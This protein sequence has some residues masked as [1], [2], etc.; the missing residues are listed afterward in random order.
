MFSDL[1]LLWISQLCDQIFR[2]GASTIR[3]HLHG[4]DDVHAEGLT[5]PRG[6]FMGEIAMWSACAF[7]GLFRPRAKCDVP[8]EPAGLVVERGSDSK[9]LAG[10]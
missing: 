1:C 4:R 2:A 9:L 5:E 10:R 3:P 8:V 7:A 6:G